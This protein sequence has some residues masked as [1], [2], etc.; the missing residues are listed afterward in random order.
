MC[1]Y[2][3]DGIEELETPRIEDMCLL[4]ECTYIRKLVKNILYKDTHLHL[5]MQP[6]HLLLVHTIHTLCTLIRSKNIDIHIYIHIEFL[7]MPMCMKRFLWIETCKCVCKH[8]YIHMYIL[9]YIHTYI[10]TYT[11]TYIH[12]YIHTYI[13][14][15][16]HTYIHTYT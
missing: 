4:G 14:T 1:V 16:I 13:H 10:R 5:Y 12:I 9:T 8:A 15:H 2:G 3:Y 11:H 6:Y 7:W